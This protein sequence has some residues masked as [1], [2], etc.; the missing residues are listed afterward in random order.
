MYFPLE[1]PLL[2]PKGFKQ[3][4]DWMT[5]MDH[6]NRCG[7]STMCWLGAQSIV[8]VKNSCLYGGYILV[9]EM[10]GVK[11]WT[12]STWEEMRAKLDQDAGR[13]GVCVLIMFCCKVS[14]IGF[15]FFFNI[16][17]LVRMDI[18]LQWVA[19]DNVYFYTFLARNLVLKS[20]NWRRCRI[21]DSPP[22]NVT[23]S[24]PYFLL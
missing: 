21:W 15:F 8:M 17:E 23:H 9:E 7:I 12:W 3:N 16:M 1:I 10:K 11:V 4:D 2:S 14:L 6:G 20:G 18:K 13:S 5:E 22:T 19:S 24:W